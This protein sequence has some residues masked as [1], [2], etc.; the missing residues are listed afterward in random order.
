MPNPILHAQLGIDLYNNNSSIYKLNF[1]AGIPKGAGIKITAINTQNNSTQV[2]YTSAIGQIDFQ[3]EVSSAFFTFTLNP[4][5]EPN[6]YVD[7]QIALHF[8]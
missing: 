5:N 3:G 7:F 1:Y 2:V 4:T 8:H 6:V